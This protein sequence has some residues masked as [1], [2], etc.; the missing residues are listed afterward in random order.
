[1]AVL[2]NDHAQPPYAALGEH[3]FFFCS[4]Y[5]AS[6]WRSIV[7]SDVI[8]SL[9]KGYNDFYASFSNLFKA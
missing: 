9:V 8:S 6:I 7:R 3:H 2:S 5:K 1:M 4:C